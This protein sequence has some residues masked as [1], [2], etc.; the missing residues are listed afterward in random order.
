MNN[1]P[2][3]VAELYPSEWLRAEDLQGK[4]VTVKVTGYELREFRRPGGEVALSC[5]LAFEGKKKR[6]IL[7]RTMCHALAE[8]MG[9]EAFEDWTGQR[10]RLCPARAPNGKATIGIIAPED[11]ADV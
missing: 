2:R 8:I 5:V 3:T 7:N 6:L 11:H 9:S 4:Q 1:L 10:V